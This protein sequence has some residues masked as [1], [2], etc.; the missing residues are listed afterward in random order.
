MNPQFLPKSAA[1]SSLPSAALTPHAA[2]A[3][4]AESAAASRTIS[5][6]EA[7]SILTR[8]PILLC[9]RHF[10][11]RRLGLAADKIACAFDVMEL[12]AFVRPASPCTP[13]VRGLAEALRQC[14]DERE[15][16]A[17]FLLQAAA[18]LAAELAAEP[19]AGKQRTLARL[20]RMA[21]QNWR[22]AEYLIAQTGYGE[23]GETEL[24]SG[25]DSYA[26][27]P[28]W[29]EHFPASAGHAVSLS[30]GQVRAQ[31]QKMLPAGRARAGQETYALAAARAF[32]L[33]A[34]SANPPETQETQESQSAHVLAEAGTGIGKT[35]AYLAPASLW[36]EASRQPVWIATYTRNLQNQLEEEI[37]RALPQQAFAVRKGRENYLCLLNFANE[38]NAPSPPL[39]AS[40]IA[41]WIPASR[42]GDLRSGDFP[43]WLPELT[44]GQI[45]AFTDRRGECIHA[46][47]P[48]YRRCFIE[49]ARTQKAPL[50]IANHAF[51]MSHA[52]RSQTRPRGETANK[53]DAA[54]QP[55][56]IFDEGHRLFDSA[57]NAFSDHLT[58]RS[59]AEL[60]TW[61][62]G[63][64]QGAQAM[65]GL[66]RR[67]SGLLGDQGEAALA[68][69]LAAGKDLPASG[70]LARL[71]SGRPRGGAE[72]FFALLADY[73]RTH[74]PERESLYS[75][76]ALYRSDESSKEARALQN[77]LAGLCADLLAPAESLAETL[78]A[79][80]DGLDENDQTL[81]TRFD[82]ALRTL[83][84]RIEEIRLWRDMLVNGAGEE[85]VMIAQ[86]TR[87]QGRI[88]DI[89]LHRHQLDPTAQFAASVLAS[90]PGTVITSATLHDS[91]AAA[92]HE[93]WQNTEWRTGAHHLAEPPHRIR[94]PSPFDY[95][96]NSRVV[97]VN[98]LPLDAVA[99]RAE[100]MAQLMQAAK[101]GAL[102]LFTS[103]AR[104]RATH[105][106]LAPKMAE[107]GI[108]L[109]AQ[110][111]DAL[112][113][114]GLIAMFRS[115][116]GSCLMGTDALRDGINV[117]GNGLRLV[118]FDRLP[119]PRPDALHRARRD[120]FGGRLYDDMMIRLRLHQGFG[121][122]L[123]SESDK[124]M[125][126]LLDGRLPARLASAFPAAAP[127]T[128]SGIAEA[129]RQAKEFFQPLNQ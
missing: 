117:P 93:N 1:K 57:D 22:W 30:A 58:A 107:A 79:A 103:I 28:E 31:L 27:L 49:R 112:S 116:T 87:Q 74:T 90:S 109:L 94:I 11:A 119:W 102:L 55:P 26:L 84:Q 52:A 76:G 8:Q 62:A 128:R 24:A 104:L 59:L 123:R 37:A 95:R 15:P 78:R 70:Y 34:D 108:L 36:A 38:E 41:R 69:F 75:L 17:G 82:A 60:S 5:R 115:E 126:V 120:H 106:L 113:A 100:A 92:E 12:F 105:Q 54:R 25:G 129:T 18:L 42:D 61:L 97:I 45:T 19:A 114:A 71:A 9:H 14:P 118:I 77:K 80:S 111:V 88:S 121:R 50:V 10:T 6:A 68:D 124:G 35:L 4:F 46:A 81:R 56:Y 127:Q 85:Q 125:F 32:G 64:R 99:A 40:F 83:E 43:S 20:K 3:S 65:R 51:V 53:A 16:D 101:G 122:L 7:V 23:I 91:A 89:G 67:L 21:Q 39:L 72:K 33:P 48:H 110:H 47:C 44:G 66:A 13:S 86:I 73:V 2:G 96:H 63:S 29:R 98:D